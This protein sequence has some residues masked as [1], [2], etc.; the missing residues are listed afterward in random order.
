MT[1]KTTDTGAPRP[2]LAFL[3]PACGSWLER[4]DQ[5]VQ[6]HLALW[7]EPVPGRIRAAKNASK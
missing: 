7:C 6:Q 1:D 3:C 2:V 5:K 4:S